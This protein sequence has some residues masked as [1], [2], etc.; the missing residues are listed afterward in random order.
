MPNTNTNTPQVAVSSC[1]QNE[2]IT[3]VIVWRQDFRTIVD[4]TPLIRGFG[5]IGRRPRARPR[6][7]QRGGIHLLALWA[8]ATVPYWQR[9]TG[10]HNLTQVL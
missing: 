9:E 5:G 1:C 10:V 6:K 3:A 2:R 7:L 8:R 4:L